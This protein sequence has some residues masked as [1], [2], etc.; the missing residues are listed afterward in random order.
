MAPSAGPT[1]LRAAI[2]RI[3]GGSAAKPG[4]ATLG[5]HSGGCAA[6]AP[7]SRWAAAAAPAQA[8]CAVS[9]KPLTRP[10]LLPGRMLSFWTCS[11]ACLPRACCLAS[12]CRLSAPLHAPTTPSFSL[13]AGV[14][15]ASAVAGVAR[16]ARDLRDEAVQQ[17]QRLAWKM[18]TSRSYF[19]WSINAAK[20][21]A[22]E[23]VDQQQRWSQETRLYDRKLLRRGGA[24]GA[25]AARVCVRATTASFL[26]APDPSPPDPPPSSRAG[27][28]WPTCA[29]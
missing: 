12:A 7:C 4:P 27:K 9:A 1:P 14:L 15:A 6:V 3:H 13:A 25:A 10:P 8:R 24:T 18:A 23:G 2:P 17:K 26:L 28:R 19:E 5:G 21:D 20:L 11:V 16:W 22:L 29:K